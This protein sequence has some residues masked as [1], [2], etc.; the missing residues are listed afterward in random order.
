ME[1]DGGWMKRG[2]EEEGE[3]EEEEKPDGRLRV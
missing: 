3:E 1:G 2:V